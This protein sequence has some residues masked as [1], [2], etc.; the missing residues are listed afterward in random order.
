M[1]DSILWVV[2]VLL[3][4]F[5]VVP[6]IGTTYTASPTTTHHVANE[7]VSID[8]QNWTSV[9]NEA[10]TYH[11]NETVY[12][13]GSVVEESEYQ[14]STSNGSIR[15]VENGS[16]AD[17]SEVSVSYSYD[18]HGRW[19]RLTRYGLY[20]I[21]AVIGVLLVIGAVAVFSTSG[22]SGRGGGR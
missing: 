21:F 18:Q 6:G 7:G 14:W 8:V 5:I 10:S 9:D 4:L 2:V 19:A 1:K 16:L 12:H 13:N 3:F 15:A 22:G 17:A 11:D 20:V